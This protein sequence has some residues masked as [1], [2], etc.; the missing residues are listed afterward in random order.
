M[1]L[2]LKTIIGLLLLPACY[3]ISLWIVD[4]FSD[5]SGNMIHGLPLDAWGLA[6]GFLLWLFIYAALPRPMRTYVLAH[7][8]TH[9]LWGW[10]MG[11]DIKGMRVS[12]TGGHVR[13]THSNFLITLAPYF[14]P[15]YTMLVIALHAG[16]SLFFDMHVLEPIW[17]GWIGLTWGFH[18]TFTISMLRT[19]QPDIEEHG[20]LFSYTLI[21]A[22]NLIGIGIWIILVTDMDWRQWSLDLQHRTITTYNDWR[23]WIVT[24][25]R[26]LNQ[27]FAVPDPSGTGRPGE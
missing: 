2:F 26:D 19:R 3:A 5:L 20:K 7:E 25:I 14:F 11:A 16:L 22:L 10:A 18:L 27:R 4:L 21:Y 12:A 6:I 15:L 13:L 1:I 17:M 23:D 8:L 24:T 9:A